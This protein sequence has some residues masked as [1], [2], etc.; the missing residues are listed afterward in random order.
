MP[1]ATARRLADS[2]RDL[3][4]LAKADVA[5]V[6]FPKSGRTFVRVMLARLYQRQFGI[7]ERALLPFAMLRRA[8][9]EVPRLLLTHDGGAMRTPQAMRINREAYRGRKVAVLVRHPG[10]IIVSRYFH[11]KYRSND[12]MR[13]RQGR[14]PLEDFIWI[15]KGGIP[16]IVKFLNN[17]A[18][19]ARQ[20]DG[21]LLLRY[22]D[23]ISDPEVTLQRLADFI[24]LNAHQAAIGDAVAFARFDNLKKLERESYFTSPKLG[25]GRE[26]GDSSYKVRSGRSGGYRG[27]LGEEQQSRV[28]AYV[29]EN[30]DPVFG[31]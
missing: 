2:W 11:L 5:L 18:E 29:A 20:R 24:G 13:Q 12:P 6:S 17:W 4:R 25:A 31:Y 16:S 21:I 7:D 10:D 3:D 14:L 26:G 1:G 27:Q 23:F 19:L 15:R 30:L 9:P 28:E 8:P 22:E